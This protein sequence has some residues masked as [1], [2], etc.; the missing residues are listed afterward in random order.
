MS[1]STIKTLVLFA[2]YTKGLSYYDDWLDAFT[3]DPQFETTA[4][5]ICSKNSHAII[6]K[7]IDHYELIILLHSTNADTLTYL[8]PFK[9]SLQSRKGILLSFVGNE[10]NLPRI[11]LNSKIVFLKKIGADFIATQLPIKAG[12]WL[13]AECTNSEVIALPHA[14][15]PQKFKPVVNQADR[16]IDIGVRTNQYWAC[17]G[18]NE[19]N[20]LIKLFRSERIPQQLKLDIRTDER[21]N[22]DGWANFLNSCKA[23]IANEAGSYYLERDD[24]TIFQINEYLQADQKIVQPTSAV[25]RIWDHIPRSIKNLCRAQIQRLMHLTGFQYYS[26]VYEQLDFDEI[27]NLFFKNTPQCPEYS[28][29]ISSRHFDAIGT[30]TCQIMLHGRYNDILRADEHYISLNHDHSNLDDVIRRF[31]DQELRTKIVEQTYEYIMSQ[32]TYDHRLQEL[33]RHICAA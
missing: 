16:T 11:P 13:Y 31:N 19:R 30:K 2:D 10:V 26:D 22:R 28:K 18:D 32:H 14:L 17:L 1:F 23:T 7:Q 33:R 12:K 21:L 9:S 24:Q 8:N 25:G 27:Y 29:A 20:D 15:N 6:R 5:N 3:R 4:L